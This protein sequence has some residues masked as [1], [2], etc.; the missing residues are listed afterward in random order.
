MGPR[1]E[2]CVRVTVLALAL[3]LMAPVGARAGETQE[4]VASLM[5]R[6]IPRNQLQ[7]YGPADYP[8]FFRWYV[9][10][11][12]SVASRDEDARLRVERATIGPLMEDFRQATGFDAT[13]SPYRQSTN[14]LLIIGTS[15]QDDFRF[16]AKDIHEISKDPEALSDL[17]GDAQP[18]SP[19]CYRNW[20]FIEGAVE[21]AILY[22]PSPF[23]DE[24]LSKKCV[25]VNFGVLLGLLG[26]PSGGQTIT[27]IG[28]QDTLFTAGDKAALRVLYDGKA[29]HPQM[30]MAEIESAI[31]RV[32]SR[33]P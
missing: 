22:A 8:T 26:K 23:Q 30:T 20:R 33:Q 29:I 27:N 10:I 19:P 11:R 13:L 4:T 15:P 28:N 18:G 1:S 5:E 3:S 2:V 32:L 17:T 16:Y 14:V 7:S 24:A 6:L 31:G 21:T 9:P 25:A 12:L